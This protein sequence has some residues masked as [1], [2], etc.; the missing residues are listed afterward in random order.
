MKI[1]RLYAITLYLL[2]HGRTS[3]AILAKHF[4]VSRRTI[5]RDM[6]ALSLYGMPVEALP[7][8]DGG[9][10]ISE[11]FTL[12]RQIVNATDY[13]QILT[14]LNG[15]ETATKDPAVQ[16]T[17][18]KIAALAQERDKSMILDLS[19]LTQ[20]NAASLKT[21]RKAAQDR[22]V[23]R[24][25]YTNARGNRHPCEVEPL[26]LVYRWYAWYLLAYSRE[27]AD[28]RTYKLI[29]MQEIV[30]TQEHY[31]QT[32]PPAEVL[33]ERQRENDTRTPIQII[34]R[35]APQACM[36]VEEYLAARRIRTLPSGYAEYELC[37]FEEEGH[38]MGM[39]LALGGL[40]EVISPMHIRRRLI[41][42]A[43]EVCAVY[44][45]CGQEGVADTVLK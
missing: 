23:V 15:L 39:L 8:P 40:A 6:E 30:V 19:V 35:C 21:L 38:Y 41:Q 9:Y 44:G 42:M 27:H 26:S 24:F 16:R 1:D 33:L 14:A 37:L 34:L 43:R 12:D 31:Q 36:R 13:S 3:A 17:R 11:A 32:H 7:G 4:E 2:D 18:E 28:F 10:A 25:I 22:K 5:Q 29:R 20:A 45:E